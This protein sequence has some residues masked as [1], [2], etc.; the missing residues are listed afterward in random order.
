MCVSFLA[1]NTL[2]PSTRADNGETI[3]GTNA[4]GVTNTLQVGRVPALY[5]KN[6]GDCLGGQSLVNLTSF[7]AAYYADNMTV[8]FNIAGA[9]SLMNESLVCMSKWESLFVSAANSDS[10]ILL[11]GSVY[12]K[13]V[14]SRNRNDMLIFPID[15]EDRYDK[16]FNPCTANFERY[17]TLPSFSLHC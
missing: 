13:V 10:S 16:I 1:L 11:G 3:E 4:A 14:V 9:T 17:R 15:G 2:I 8:L 7:D 5:T 6:F 12:V